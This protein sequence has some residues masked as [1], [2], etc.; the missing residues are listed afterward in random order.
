MTDNRKWLRKQMPRKENGNPNPI[1]KAVL[2]ALANY[3]NEVGHCFP[4]QRALSLFTGYG[5]SSIAHALKLLEEQGYIFRERRSP[6]FR[7]QFGGTDYWLNFE[8]ADDDLGR[9]IP[10]PTGLASAQA[11]RQS[12]EPRR[13][14]F[15]KTGLLPDTGLSSA[16]TPVQK[17]AEAGSS[18]SGAGKGLKPGGKAKSASTSKGSGKPKKAAGKSKRKG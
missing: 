7:Q 16:G 2:T 13:I 9:R 8:K 11:N 15:S 18:P 5:E 10:Q 6:G 1:A 17:R 12:P 14:P 3:A 4:S